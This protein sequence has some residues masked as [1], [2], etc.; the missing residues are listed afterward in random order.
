MAIFAHYI[1]TLSVQYFQA[2]S[3]IIWLRSCDMMSEGCDTVYGRVRY[4]CLG[5]DTSAIQ[6][7]YH[8]ILYTY[9]YIYICIIIIIIIIYIYIHI[10]I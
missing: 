5:L 9:I 7:S 1:R 8:D 3:C 6:E 2:K 10:Y 4:E